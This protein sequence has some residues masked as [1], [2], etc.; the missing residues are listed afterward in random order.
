LESLRQEAKTLAR[1]A[2]FRWLA[3]WVAD[4]LLERG[5]LDEGTVCPLL[6]EADREYRG[7][8]YLG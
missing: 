3:T 7:S 8:R 6:R 1:S 5:K 4:A 2:R